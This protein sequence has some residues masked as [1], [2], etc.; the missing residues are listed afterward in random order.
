MVLGVTI[1]RAL[2]YT[3]PLSALIS[4]DPESPQADELRQLLN[5]VSGRAP[6]NQGRTSEPLVKEELAIVEFLTAK[7][8]YK[9]AANSADRTQRGDDQTPVDLL[10]GLA[11]TRSGRRA[12]EEEKRQIRLQQYREVEE[13]RA[14]AKRTGG[15]S[16]PW[17]Y[18][19]PSM[20]GLDVQQPFGQSNQRGR[21]PRPLQPPP[22]KRP[23]GQQDSPWGNDIFANLANDVMQP[24]FNQSPRRSDPSPHR[25]SFGQ[26]SANSF[27]LSPFA[28]MSNMPLP[29]PSSNIP[30]DLFN[31]NPNPNMSTNDV[32]QQFGQNILDGFDFSDLGLNFGTTAPSQGL[33]AASFNPF[34]LAQNASTAADG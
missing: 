28:S 32:S 31:S 9:Q 18:V 16:S 8:N 22:A 24:Q 27:S 14:S 34:A 5:I 23:N 12:A 13:Q 15:M 25:G 33:D 2:L 3:S 7:T 6:D 11:K 20:P 19:A 29:S 30:N 10:L 21:M 1:K 26:Q 4:V 17:G